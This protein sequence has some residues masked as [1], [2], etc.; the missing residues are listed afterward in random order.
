MRIKYFN[1]STVQ[2]KR[3]NTSKTNKR[4]SNLSKNKAKILIVQNTNKDF[5]IRIKISN[6]SKF[7]V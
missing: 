1:L 2:I 3:L 4:T 7:G 6:W 5:K